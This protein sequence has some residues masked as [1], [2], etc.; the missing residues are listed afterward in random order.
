M[1]RHYPAQ[2]EAHHV[3]MSGLKHIGYEGRIAVLARDENQ[4]AALKST[5]PDKILYPFNDAADYAAEE[6]AGLVRAD[7]DE[8]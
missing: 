4:V 3:L 8:A 1:D 6:L 5:H 7:E 2:S